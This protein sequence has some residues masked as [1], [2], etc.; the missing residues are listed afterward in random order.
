MRYHQIFANINILITWKYEHPKEVCWT[1]FFTY[2][3]CFLFVIL[4]SVN[5][6]SLNSNKS[7]K[8][9]IK[10]TL[11]FEKQTWRWKFST[12]ASFSRRCKGAIHSHIYLLLPTYCSTRPLLVRKQE[13]GYSPETKTKNYNP[14]AAHHLPYY[15]SFYYIHFGR[16]F[17]SL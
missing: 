7:R 3:I 12:M 17:S 10:T 4:F 15:F 8:I 14:A 16:L 5:K 11:S 2:I 9:E 1:S 13:K 6:T